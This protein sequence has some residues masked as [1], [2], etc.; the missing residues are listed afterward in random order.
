MREPLAPRW[1]WA[2]ALVAATSPFWGLSRPLTEADDAR[3]AAVPREMALSGD[4]TVPTLNGLPY[5][6]KPPLYYWLGAASQ[7]LFG[8]SERSA[9]LPLALLALAAV[10][11]TAWLGSW[12]FSARTGAAAAVALSSAGLFFVHAHYATLD[13][14]LTACLAWSSAFI[15][16][17][18]LKP[19]DARWSAPAA[20]GAAALAV[21]AKGLVGLL[22]PLAFAA[23][24]ALLYKDWCRGLKALLRPW[25]PLLFVAITAPWFFLIEERRPGFW[26]FFFGEQHFQRYLTPKYN[27]QSPVFFFLL[28]VPATML[29]WTPAWLSAAADAAK[30]WRERR[31]EAALL[32]W[33]TMIV[34]FFSLSKSKLVPYALPAAPHLALLAARALEQPLP[35]WAKRLSWALGVLLLL[36]PAAGPALTFLRPEDRPP[37]AA[38]FPALLAV[39]V[40]GLALLAVGRG[41]PS[42]GG[43][44]IARLGL[45]GLASGALLL[46]ALAA[47]E[48]VLSARALALAVK[49]RARAGSQVWTYGTYL[50]G[51]PFYA[52][53]P[54]DKIIYWIGELDYAKRDS[55][56]AARFGDDNDVRALPRAGGRTFVA[57]RR[58]EAP[59][60]F[61]MTEPGEV[62]R[63]EVFGKWILAEFAAAEELP[64]WRRRR[65][66]R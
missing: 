4:W 49:E 61:S 12:L 13:M 26:A 23:A 25:G 19:Q 22:F 17:A 1:L 9:R 42:R 5:V 29:P 46:A 32:L 37:D 52:E 8:C 40:L 7:S 43:R 64:S 21:L 66:R 34:A 14:G 33:A 18:A 41:E 10:A 58:F 54:V 63:Q 27:R 50:H 39:S 55:V 31:A 20:W 59:H 38:L 65:F 35:A 62:V 28:V 3:Y 48:P 57:L 24:L 2:L 45:S 30:K 15:L 47:A 6:E 56:N 60:F 16:R 51:L 53:R 11:A 36:T 44:D